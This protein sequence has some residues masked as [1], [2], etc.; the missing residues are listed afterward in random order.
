[1]LHKIIDRFNFAYLVGCGLPYPRQLTPTRPT[2][3]RK[4]PISLVLP[5]ISQ[6]TDPNGVYPQHRQGLQLA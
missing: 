2:K 5:T 3:N 4:S 6:F 1:M